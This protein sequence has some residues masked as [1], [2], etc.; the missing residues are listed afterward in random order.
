MVLKCTLEKAGKNAA[1]ALEAKVVGSRHSWDEASSEEAAEEKTF[2]LAPTETDGK[3]PVGG[4]GGGRETQ[5]FYSD[6]P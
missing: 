4:A 6:S 2:T 1:S 5:G 3:T